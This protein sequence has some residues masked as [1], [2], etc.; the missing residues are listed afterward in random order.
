MKEEDLYLPIKEFF[1]EQGYA[2]YGE[3]KDIDVVM[4]KDDLVHAIELKPAFNLKLILQAVER[5]RYMDSVY[6]AIKKPQYNKRYKEMIHLLKRLEIGLITVDFLKTKTK[7]TVEHHPIPLQKRT[8]NKKKRMV[9]KEVDSR[10]AI[11]DN[12]GGST[13]VKRMTAYREQAL[14]I[15]Y[16]MHIRDLS[17]PKDIKALI[18]LDK[19]GQILYQNYYKWFERVD[20]GRY[21]LTALGLEALTTYYTTVSHLETLLGKTEHE[22]V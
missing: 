7:V 20:K 12:L 3:V 14:M 13:K 18:G 2:V 22:E 16:V 6:V 10:L 21:K 17:K 1:M 4:K 19:T 5:Q 15:A 8:N 11:E 9:I